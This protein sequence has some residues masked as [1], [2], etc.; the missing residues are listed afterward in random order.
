MKV[1]TTNK[2]P[3]KDLAKLKGLSTEL[4]QV[5]SLLVKNDIGPAMVLDADM[6]LLTA[7]DAFFD[8]FH[9]FWGVT[10]E[11]DNRLSS[12]I[13]DT[14]HGPMNTMIKKA[15]EALSTEKPVKL[16]HQISG[17]KQSLELKASFTPIHNLVHISFFITPI[18]REKKT[19]EF[20]NNILL[21]ISEVVVCFDQMG[22]ITYWNRGAEQCFGF[23]EM[24]MLGSNIRKL[25]AK[26]DSATILQDLKSKERPIRSNWTYKKQDGT[27][28]HLQVST[29]LM[30]DSRNKINGVIATAIDI[31]EAQSLRRIIDNTHRA[32]LVGG[33]E[34]NLTKQTPIWTEETYKIHDVPLGKKVTLEEAFV[35]YHVD[36]RPK[37]EEA[38]SK[39]LEDGTPYDM[40]IRFI[41]AKNVHKWVRVIG[42]KE[43]DDNEE[44]T[45]LGTIQ[46]ITK[47]KKA[48]EKERASDILFKNT[49]DNAGIGM[50]LVDISG[51]LIDANPYMV[52]LLGFPKKELLK[53][54]FPEFTHTDDI[55]KDLHLF[56]KTLNGEIDVYEM[57]KRYITANGDVVWVQLNV[58]MY[59]NEAGEAL[60]AIAMV[61]DISEKVKAEEEIKQLNIDLEKRVAERTK[62]LTEINKEM[63]TFSYLM[64]HDLRT[65]LRSALLFSDIL[66]R[67]YLDGLPEKGAEIYQHMKSS[68]VEM[69]QL[70]NDLLEYAK[71]RNNTI[72]AHTINTDHL[73]DE[74]L[75]DIKKHYEE[76]SDLKIEVEKLPAIKGDITLLYHAFRN[77][78]SNSF[79]YRKEDTSLKLS[80][81]VHQKDKHTV[82]FALQDNGKG[83][84]QKFC[85]EIFKPFERLVL[86]SD[87]QGSGIGLS[88][89]E[90]I[91]NKHN[92]SVRAE[93][94]EGK[95][96][97]FYVTLPL[98]KV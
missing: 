57:P 63:E 60:M 85:E 56:Q 95:G 93:G 22:D 98:A 79:K 82:T 10:P 47:R 55:E 89:V 21:N 58:S 5:V 44:V 4:S 74:V 9:R 19:Q 91:I 1:N 75:T 16:F 26:L 30:F 14:K 25:E 23:T 2:P 66:G 12:G 48:E 69:D 51:V 80:I 67:K 37:L 35:F 17:P 62:E 86:K 94:E 65:P 88:I 46:D 36:D 13:E 68:L 42:H 53:K 6:S 61:Q 32:A 31:T 28:L 49:F 7:N 38:F 29:D 73:L 96:A 40:E 27:K 3:S 76:I 72:K 87:V 24:E 18:E 11:I 77:I 78:I 92:G 90:R 34:I 43:V 84:N 54:S 70:V 59:R 83:F 50:A 15:E 97:C 33:W 20:L 39:L 45:V 81:K 71:I 8:C 41:T 52:N 64:S